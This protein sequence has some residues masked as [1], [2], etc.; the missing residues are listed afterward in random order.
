MQ[1]TAHAVTDVGF[2]DIVAARQR[3]AGGVLVTPCVESPALSAI[4]GAQIFCKLEY[5]QRAGSFKERGACN[6]LLLLSAEERS[7][8]V[9]AASAGNHAL[10]LALHGKRLGI[11]VT[12]VMPMHAP[13][14]KQRRCR[15][16]GA[17]VLNHGDNIA[18]ARSRAD[19]LVADE[20]LTYINGFN[21]AA[22]VAGQGTV[23]LEILEQV[24]DLDAI[25]VPI[26]GAGLIAGIALA[27][28]ELAPRVKIVG[29]EPS[30]CASFAAA[31]AAGKPV[32]VSSV[33]TLADGLAVPEVG[34]RSFEIA[35]TRVD[36][37]VAVDE[38]AIALAILRLAELEKGVVEGAGAA[39]LAAFLAGKLDSLKGKRVALVLCGGNIDPLVFSRVIEQGLAV[40]GRL[41][42]FSAVIS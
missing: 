27:T 29:V 39:P 13:L 33:A 32:R 6:A 7:R 37:W 34:A 23:G 5:Q 31:M 17:R 42:K 26:G 19:L 3:I 28:K 40:D 20:R 1:A 18:E 24:H 22:I 41:V 14:V 15:E 38:N 10:A 11:P 30:R 16:L 4:T 2:A 25:V 36:E 9:I 12:V 8:G 35:R 21:D